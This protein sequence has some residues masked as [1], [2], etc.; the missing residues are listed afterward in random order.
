ML[1][2]QSGIT[3]RNV[4]FDYTWWT[5]SKTDF[6][7]TLRGCLGRCTADGGARLTRVLN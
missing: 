3:S 4:D 1:R 5:T 7:A 2:P 6:D